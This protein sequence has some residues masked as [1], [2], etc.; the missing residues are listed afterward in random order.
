MVPFYGLCLEIYRVIPKRNY[1]GAYGYRVHQG[2]GFVLLA[3]G[4]G[5]RVFYEQPCSLNPGRGKL[6]K[7]GDCSPPTRLNS[8]MLLG[9]RTSPTIGGVQGLGFA[10]ESYEA[11]AARP[12]RKRTRVRAAMT[13]EV[14][15]HDETVLLGVSHLRVRGT[16]NLIIVVPKNPRA[17]VTTA[18][19]NKQKRRVRPGG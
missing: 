2:S 7:V 3:G 11:E 4:F 9:P 10:C 12:P 6:Q 16:C 18:A 17:V 15:S 8:L 1:L 19:P 14:T 5:V 13:K